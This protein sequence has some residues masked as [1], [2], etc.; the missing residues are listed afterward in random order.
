MPKY[1]LLRDGV[2]AEGGVPPERM[3]APGRAAV[4]DLLLV[5]TP[6]YV[7]QVTTGTLPHAEQRRIGLPWSEAFV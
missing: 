3:H 6:E 2:L 5:H 4:E 7:E 1:A